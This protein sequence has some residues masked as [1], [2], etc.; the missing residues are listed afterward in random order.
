MPVPQS[1]AHSR[2]AMP[3]HTETKPRSA[4]SK[5]KYQLKTHTVTLHRSVSWKCTAKRAFIQLP[6]VAA[7]NTDFRKKTCLWITYFTVWCRP[8]SDRTLPKYRQFLLSRLFTVIVIL[9]I[10]GCGFHHFSCFSLLAL[11]TCQMNFLPSF[12]VLSIC[13]HLYK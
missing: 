10:P 2:K 5:A 12:Y 6:K 1:D 13:N 3:W 11:Y 4:G 9:L 8:N 7:R